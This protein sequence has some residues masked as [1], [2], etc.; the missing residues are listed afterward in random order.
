MLFDFCNASTLARHLSD[1]RPEIYA[2]NAATGQQL[3]SIN[4]GGAIPAG[5]RWG[6]PMPLSALAAGESEL[7]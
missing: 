3:W 2:L 7:R 5:A 1:P 6:A 4:A